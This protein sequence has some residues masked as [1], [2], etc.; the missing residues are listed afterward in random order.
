MKD[1]NV[2]RVFDL[3]K[4]SVSGVPSDHLTRNFNI[5]L[6]VL[7]H[8]SVWAS[9]VDGLLIWGGSKARHG[10]WSTDISLE[11]P[12]YLWRTMYLFGYWRAGYRCSWLCGDT[13]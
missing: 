1:Q 8:R 5:D 9:I 13:L 11:S 2:A 7:Q 4:S 10:R 3:R 6:S 12:L